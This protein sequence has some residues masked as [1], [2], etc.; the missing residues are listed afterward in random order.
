MISV[1]LIAPYHVKYTGCELAFGKGLKPYFRKK[2]IKLKNHIG[3]DFQEC[4]QPMYKE[5][6][7]RSCR[8][9]SCSCPMPI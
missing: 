9:I 6:E 8:I 2:Q 4:K 3:C 1:I 7:T 5:K